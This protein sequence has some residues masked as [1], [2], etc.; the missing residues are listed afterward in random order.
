MSLTN[1]D[2]DAATRLAIQQAR[3][4]LLAFVNESV[5]IC[6]AL[7]R[8]KSAESAKAKKKSKK[9]SRSHHGHDH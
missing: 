6:N 7:D 9:S 8:K 2:R 4:D 1:E 5:K 3:D